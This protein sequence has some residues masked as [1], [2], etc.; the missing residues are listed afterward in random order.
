M[1]APKP[2][3]FERRCI[4]S[5]NLMVKVATADTNPTGGGGGITT[6]GYHMMVTEA[7]GDEANESGPV[8]HIESCVLSGTVPDMAKKTHK[9]LYMPLTGAA[10]GMFLNLAVACR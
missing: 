1:R 2:L 9:E 10:G 7:K 4:K 6:G 5:S 3:R 8:A